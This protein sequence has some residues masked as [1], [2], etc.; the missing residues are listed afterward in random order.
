MKRLTI[1]LLLVLI[2]ASCT[3]Y[4]AYANMHTDLRVGSAQQA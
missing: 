4:P 3:A 1:A 2:V